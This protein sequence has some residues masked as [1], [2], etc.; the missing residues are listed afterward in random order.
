MHKGHLVTL[1]VGLLIAVAATQAQDNVW[2]FD[3][4]TPK[5]PVM[6]GY[7]RLAASQTYNRAK[8]YG[9]ERGKPANLE[10][11]R[12][13]RNPRLRGSAG[14]LLLE[15]AYDNHRNALNRD[16]VASRGDLG[17]RLDVPDGAYRVSITMGDL[18]KAIGLDRPYSKRLAG[19]RAVGRLGA[20]RVSPAGHHAGRMVEYFSR[21][22]QGDRRGDSDYLEEEPKAL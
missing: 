17:F 15:E 22:R 19:G 10:F 13:V 6:E 4:G 12:P 2:R 7:Q 9:W 5:S 21:D 8:G 14:Q 20:R 1:T 18:S 11:R 3:C 16:G